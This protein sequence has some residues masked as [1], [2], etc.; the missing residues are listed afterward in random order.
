M[1]KVDLPELLK[2]V[3]DIRERIE[4]VHSS[5]YRNFLQCYMPSFEHILVTRVQPQFV[6]NDSNKIRLV[7][8]E[9]MNRLPSNDV[10]KPYINKLIVLVMKI[11]E[12]DNEEN[13]LLCV[14]ILFD[15]HKNFRPALKQY[16][17]RFLEFV[18]N[19]YERLENTKRLIFPEDPL[20]SSVGASATSTTVL[21][22]AALS[23]PSSTAV[24]NSATAAATPLVS[25]SGTA[26]AT[27]STSTSTTSTTSTSSTSSTSTAS[28]STASFT[29]RSTPKIL[30]R[31]TCSFKVLTECPLIVMLLFQLYGEYVGHY[32]EVFIPLMTNGLRLSAPS[33]Q[34]RLRTTLSK[35][36]FSEMVACQVKTLS[37]LTYLIKGF[38]ENMLPHQE[39]IATSVVMLLKRCPDESV[40]TRKELLV[41]TRHILAT[42]FRHG[43]FKHVDTM[44]R[45]DVL[46]GNGRH[47]QAVLR[48][49]AYSTVADLVHHVRA[50]LGLDQLSKVIYIF[51]RNIHDDE[52][53]LSIQTTSVRL[54]L[55]LVDNIF[56][57]DH[58]DHMNGW[59][60]L[61][62]ILA[63]LVDKFE[64][65]VEYIP[66]LMEKEKRQI[67]KKKTA[68]TRVQRKINSSHE[69]H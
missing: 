47:A 28:S 6:S 34:V 33:M 65:L 46:I 43:F 61:I 2:T 19:L 58:P 56:H 38:K 15:L 64:T 66:L 4:I 16:V 51:S 23:L 12:E 21:P 60:L 49:L 17:P 1:R 31:S 25:A 59:R 18:Q 67:R 24:G 5:E 52:L 45:E 69:E 41:A 3:I 13:A 11:M 39:T 8:L 10:L 57:N 29:T 9:I 20:S 54:L 53:P 48:P 50:K 68:G 63:A 7:V 22:S 37:F 62:R 32:V 44:L 42:D 35:I 40:S 14:R 55:N 36:R 27:A 30:M 26:A